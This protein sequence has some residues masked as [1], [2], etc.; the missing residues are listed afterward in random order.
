MQSTR[1][2][3]LACSA[4]KRLHLRPTLPEALYDGPLWRCWRLWL[5]ETE[6]HRVMPDLVVLSAR[7]G[8]IS[9]E[10]EIAHYDTVLTPARAQEVLAAPSPVLQ[11]AVRNA[12]EILLLG[13]ALYRDTMR[14]A[15]RQVDFTGLV[16]EPEPNRGIGDQI[17]ALDRFM[18]ASPWLP[19]GKPWPP[20]P[21]QFS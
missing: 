4:R 5:I 1:C 13:G 6:G 20:A 10:Q 21:L 8:I 16:R 14:E 3:F 12:A 2:V 9:P 17:A 18:R 11:Q 15:L 7:H 19:E